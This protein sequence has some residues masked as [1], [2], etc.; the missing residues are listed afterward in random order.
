MRSRRVAVAVA[1]AVVGIDISLLWPSAASA[2]APT[3]VGGWRI[4]RQ[5]TPA[6]AVPTSPLTDD[7]TLA[8]RNGPAGVLAFAA[9]RYEGG[10][11]TLLLN[12]A[13]QPPPTAPAIDACR[14]T[15]TW[16]TGADQVWDSRPT[17]DCA[18]HLAATVSG[19]QLSWQLDS[20]F[21]NGGALDVA[22]VPDPADTTPYAVSFALP[23]A[24]S[25]QPNDDATTFAPP[26]PPPAA[27]PPASTGGPGISGGGPV[28][29]AL[30]A[31]AA[32]AP[33]VAPASP[34]AAPQIAAA[35]T[36][37]TREPGSRAAGAGTL[38]AFAFI[39]LVR[40]FVTGGSRGH[41]PRS[42]LLINREGA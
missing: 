31:P 9:V 26:P 30:D 38:A 14:V 18:H 33:L 35:P 28:A 8:V 22:L 16:T 2:S 34:S 3:A 6:G 5:T 19:S 29:P 42:L 32:S 12:L 21:V 10:G 4:E 13:G 17:Y 1:L 27:A 20:G 11:G 36:A 24:A 37:A 41:A 40:S 25:F 39:L 15:S 23:T 7:G